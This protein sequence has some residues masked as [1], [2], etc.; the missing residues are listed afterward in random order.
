MKFEGG[1][2]DGQVIHFNKSLNCL[3]GGKGTGKSTVIELIRYTL[4]NLSNDEEIREKEEKHIQ[5]VLGI[6]KISM[7]IEINSGDRYLIEKTY[8]DKPRILRTDEEEV[9][10][11]IGQFKQEFFN[12]DAYS[13]TEL[14]EIA[15]NFKNQLK[16][17][18]QYIN[19]ENLKLDRESIR[20]DLSI[21]EGHIVEKADTISELKGKIGEIQTIRERLRGLESRGVKSTLE[22]HL[23]WEEEKQILDNMY[24]SLEKEVQE[25]TNLQKGHQ[26]NISIPNFKEIENLPEQEILKESIKL[27]LNSK[28]EVK[29]I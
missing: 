18:D 7:A 3:I 11:D 27:L 2:L 9:D 17:I 25:W 16:M 6:G 4:D 22:D 5:D 19:F 26:T 28:D 10:I 24:N 14:L 13:Q 8:D 1:F 29:L 20:K 23:L 15:R 21:N 12:V